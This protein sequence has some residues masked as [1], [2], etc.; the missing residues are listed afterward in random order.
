IGRI[1][2]A[3]C[4][5]TE[6]ADATGA[7][8]D[9]PAV[10]ALDPIV[11]AGPLACAATAWLP[12]ARATGRCGSAGKRCTAAARGAAIVGAPAWPA[13]PG[14]DPTGEAAARMGAGRAPP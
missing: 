1:S 3:A 6:A 12:A 5:W 2:G 8:V 10:P 7:A 11:A 13:A 14:G 4:V 9:A